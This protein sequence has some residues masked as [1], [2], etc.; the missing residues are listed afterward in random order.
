MLC[1]NAK[2]SFLSFLCFDLSSWQLS[3]T[4]SHQKFIFPFSFQ[5]MWLVRICVEHWLLG[6]FQYYSHPKTFTRLN[7]Q[8]TLLKTF[9]LYCPREWISLMNGVWC[10][11]VPVFLNLL[12]DIAKSRKGSHLCGANANCI[13]TSSSYTCF[14]SVHKNAEKRPRLISSHLDRTSL[15]NKAFIT[16]QKDFASLRIKKILVNLKRRDREP[17]VFA[18]Q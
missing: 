6:S 2:W 4:I 11:D 18:A 17:T 16:W 1:R 13:N 12:S 9:D 15:A 5:C 8:D 10:S 14:D 3:W 7:G